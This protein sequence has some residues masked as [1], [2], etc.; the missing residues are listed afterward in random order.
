VNS[1]QFTYGGNFTYLDDDNAGNMRTY[2]E[3][4]LDKIYTNT[5]IGTVDY[6]NGV[7]VLKNFLPVAYDGLYITLDVN[8]ITQNFIPVR[9]QI[10]LISDSI[11]TVYD[12]TS[13][14]ELAK[15]STVSTIG[16]TTA[17][18]ETAIATVTSY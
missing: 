9:N 1:S 7:I 8:P 4:G 17:T 12:D 3:T 18:N 13:G 11:V 5:N 10:L 14:K 2:Y 15:V 6:V 16:E